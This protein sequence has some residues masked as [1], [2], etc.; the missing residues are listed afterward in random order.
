MKFR[1][2]CQKTSSRT[3]TTGVLLLIERQHNLAFW[4]MVLALIGLAGMHMIYWVFTHTTNRIWLRGSET[5]TGKAGEAFFASGRASQSGIS[6]A[7][8]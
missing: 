7:N 3:H 5:S 2:I 6:T 8:S 4:L 1:V